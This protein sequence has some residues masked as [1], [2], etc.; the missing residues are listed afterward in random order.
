MFF[1]IGL[2]ADHYDQR[3]LYRLNCRFTNFFYY[4]YE[5]GFRFAFLREVW[6]TLSRL[7]ESKGYSYEKAPYCGFHYSG[8][9]NRFVAAD[10][11]EGDGGGCTK[12]SV[13]GFKLYYENVEGE[14]YY[15]AKR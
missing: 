4:A 15:I 12:F 8:Y 1:R 5:E 2:Y 11:H 13:F 7:G 9:E 6:E 14:T 10:F 3:H